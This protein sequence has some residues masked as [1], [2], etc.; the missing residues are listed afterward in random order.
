VQPGSIAVRTTIDRSRPNAIA[1]CAGVLAAIDRA[2]ASIC[3][4]CDEN[5]VASRITIAIWSLVIPN[6]LACLPTS[7]SAGPAAIRAT[8]ELAD[9]K[10]S[11]KRPLQMIAG[12]RHG[13][14][15]KLPRRRKRRLSS[16]R[17]SRTL[18][19]SLTQKR[20]R[21]QEWGGC[22]DQEYKPRKPPG[23]I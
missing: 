18:N 4:T 1:A 9:A 11:E 16:R 5:C 23:T 3:V 12:H 22:A 8:L 14:P 13:E 7:R 17:Y 21:K 19:R 6:S 2:E 10:R 20:E 15:G